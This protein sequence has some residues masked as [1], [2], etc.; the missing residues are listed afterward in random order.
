[1]F[2]PDLCASATFSDTEENVL[3]SSSG[4]VLCQ[5]L[6]KIYDGVSLRTH[7]QALAEKMLIADAL[8]SLLVVSSTAKIVALE[9]KFD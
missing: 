1:M 4:A 9:S 7:E 3:S 5:A 6:V 8:K 2:S